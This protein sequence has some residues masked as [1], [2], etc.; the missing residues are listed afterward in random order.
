MKF[1]FVSLIAFAAACSPYSPDLGPAPFLCGPTDP[2][3]PDGYLCVSQGSAMV[4]ANGDALPDAGVGTCNDDSSLEP[5]D[6]VGNAHLFGALPGGMLKLAGLAIC[7]AMDKDTYKIPA[8]TTGPNVHTLTAALTFDPNQAVLIVNFLGENGM[9]I[10]N[11]QPNGNGMAKAALA[12]IPTNGPPTYVQI[13]VAP[14][15][16]LTTNGDYKLDLTMN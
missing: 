7:P 12:T 15:Q 2:K 5:N 16:T 13:S 10:V 14:S 11:S 4:C 1:A 8:P 9:V 3:C 6:T